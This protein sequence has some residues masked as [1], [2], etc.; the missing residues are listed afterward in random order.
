[1]VV[2]EPRTLNAFT[3]AFYG[4]K[5]RV[6]EWLGVSSRACQQIVIRHSPG[7]TRTELLS[8]R[9]AIEQQL[10]DSAA[11]AA[12]QLDAAVWIQPK[13]SGCMAAKT[14]AIKRYVGAR[15]DTY[16][17]LILSLCMPCDALSQVP[18]SFGLMAPSQ[19]SATSFLRFGVVCLMVIHMAQEISG[20]GSW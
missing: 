20:E 16:S 3:T 9:P 6:L 13:I 1:M 5:Q 18:Y 15:F 2:T 19:C 17:H 4:F 10:L 11:A 7:G 12:D 8:G 14:C